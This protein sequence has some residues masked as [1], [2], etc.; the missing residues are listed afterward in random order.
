M[1][2]NPNRLELMR[3]AKARKVTALRRTV[4]EG[5]RQLVAEL[6][7]TRARRPR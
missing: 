5:L 4:S 7:G 3:R 6:P 1:A 2:S